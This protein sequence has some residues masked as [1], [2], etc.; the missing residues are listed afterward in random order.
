MEGCPPLT[1]VYILKQIVAPDE[2][3]SLSED[4]WIHV[5]SCF[6]S[7]AFVLLPGK[8]KEKEKGKKN[9]DSTPR[10]LWSQ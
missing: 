1:V 9:Q 8:K 7:P 2:L 3:Y 10:P 5:P 6:Q 4:R